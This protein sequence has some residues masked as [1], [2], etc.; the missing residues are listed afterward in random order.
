MSR[1][2]LT[3]QL[4]FATLLLASSASVFVAL[5]L[6]RAYRSQYRLTARYPWLIAFTFGLLR[7]FAFAGSRAQIGLPEH[8]IPLS[9]LLF[10]VGVEVGQLS[11]VGVVVL[12]VETLKHLPR[13]LPHWTTWIP[14]YA[15]GALASFWVMQRLHF[16]TR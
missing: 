8:N 10:N 6:T 16:L 9:F 12:S 11:F 7:G 14:P 5:E 1:T 3:E 13:R 15:I 2:F 4:F